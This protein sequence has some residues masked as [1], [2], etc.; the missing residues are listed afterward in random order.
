MPSRRPSAHATPSTPTRH[1]PARRRKPLS[2]ELIVGAAADLAQRSG[3][4]AVTLRAVAREVRVSPMA[5]Y[6]HVATY[7]QLLDLVI[8]ELIAREPSATV[9]WPE[10]WPER[11]RLVAEQIR[12]SVMR[13]P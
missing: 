11:I 9:R 7:D 13:H 12:S 8:E 5:L 4:D 10:G 3:L 6:R 2:R 1:R